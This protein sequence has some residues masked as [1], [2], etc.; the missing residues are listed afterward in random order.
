MLVPGELGCLGVEPL[1]QLGAAGRLIRYETFCQQQV[2][3]G[4]VAPTHVRRSPVHVAAHTA[5]QCGDS[6][7]VFQHVYRDF[8][9]SYLIR[10]FGR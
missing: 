8:A 9:D 2:R 10:C 6:Y 4:L 3:P 5:A 1:E 7:S